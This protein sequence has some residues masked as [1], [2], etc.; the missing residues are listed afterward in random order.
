MPM[1]LLS[2]ARKGGK[3]ALRVNKISRRGR[4]ALINLYLA[5]ATSAFH[6]FDTFAP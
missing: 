6:L 2:E 3:A 1:T 5:S 4:D